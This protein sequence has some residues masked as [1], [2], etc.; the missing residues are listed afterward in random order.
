M[1]T[2][3]GSEITLGHTLPATASSVSAPKY[4][5]IIYRLIDYKIDGQGRINILYINLNQKPFDYELEAFLNT[6]LPASP[7]VDPEYSGRTSS[8]L[9]I[10]CQEKCHIVL[11]LANGKN[12]QFSEVGDC[13]ST[14]KNYGNK[15]CDLWHVLDDGT[16][17]GGGKELPEGCRILYFTAEGDKTTFW[18]G[19]NL[20]VDIV[21]DDLLL[22]DG[23]KEKR[24][25]KL[26][27][28][29]DIR[30]PGG[31]GEP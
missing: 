21:L 4:D 19:F 17:I 9:D 26:I 16:K 22:P 25:T 31:T 23:N 2:E 29:P 30:N 1:S 15:Y 27:I 3:P 7:F 10:N 14:K 13:F 12:W 18:D 28:D 24:R 11:Q 8:P 6:I 20:R 5:R